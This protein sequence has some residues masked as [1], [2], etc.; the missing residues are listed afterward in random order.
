[1]PGTTLI[2]SG[3]VSPGNSPGILTIN[4]NYTQTSSGTLLIQINGH[5]LGTEY[6]QLK[7]TGTATLG[8]N[9]GVSVGDF[10]YSAGDFGYSIGDFGYSVGDFTSETIENK[11]GV[12]I[13]QTGGTGFSILLSDSFKVYLPLTIR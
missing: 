11:P 10:G 9:L 6:S 12:V 13:D 3:T 4:G 2:N 7:V 8:G 5:T 1:M